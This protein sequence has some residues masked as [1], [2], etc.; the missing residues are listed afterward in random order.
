MGNRSSSFLTCLGIASIVIA[1]S[2][3]LCRAQSKERPKLKNFGSSLKRTRWDPKKQQAVVAKPNVKSKD[4]ED[5]DVVKVETSL[6][7]SDVLV[8]DARGNPV[9]GLTEN[10]FLSSEDGEQQKLEMFSSGT[11]SN[12]PRT[13][14]LIIDYSS[15]QRPVL[16]YCT[17]SLIRRRS[18]SSRPTNQK[19]LRSSSM[20]TGC[21]TSV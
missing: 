2:L 8:L 12:V 10:N 16:D 21:C 19:T 13:I 1:S 6:V 18:R 9:D 3:N 7:S 17:R 14:V 4:D 11:N 15:S 5:L 20:R